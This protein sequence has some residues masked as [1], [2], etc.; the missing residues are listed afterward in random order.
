MLQRAVQH[1]HTC[2]ARPQRRHSQVMARSGDT[3]ELRPL[4]E[5]HAARPRHHSYTQEHHPAPSPRP[6]SPGTASSWPR[7]AICRHDKPADIPTSL[8]RYPPSTREDGLALAPRA[9]T[10][11]SPNYQLPRAKPLLHLL[12]RSSSRC[13]RLQPAALIPAVP[14][15]NAP[16]S[17]PTQHQ[18]YWLVMKKV[19]VGFPSPE[20]HRPTA[21]HCARDGPQAGGRIQ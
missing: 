2:T 13:N 17:I 1:H 14:S 11:S 7:N 12:Q 8:P 6:P 5:A 9:P 20:S 15:S 3:C 16:I 18:C 19:T 4:P 10:A 21:L